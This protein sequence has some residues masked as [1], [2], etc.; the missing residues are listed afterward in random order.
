MAGLLTPSVS[1]FALIGTPS[2]FK[3]LCFL[4]IKPL[5]FYINIVFVFDIEIT[6]ILTD[7][8]FCWDAG[9]YIIFP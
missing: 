7:V 6:F 8:C 3:I 9:E 5:S 1:D 4:P 2:L